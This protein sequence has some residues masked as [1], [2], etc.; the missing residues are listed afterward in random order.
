MNRLILFVACV[1]SLVSIWPI[2]A[3]CLELRDLPPAIQRHVEQAQS[4]CSEPFSVGRGFAV[5]KDIN[6][7]ARDDYVL[8]YGEAR[9]GAATSGYC[10]SGGCLTQVFVSKADGTFSVALDMNVR[11]LNFIRHGG[12]P[13]M[14]LD[15]HGSFCGGVGADPC[16]KILYFDG[17]RADVTPAQTS[18]PAE[19]ER[20][21]AIAAGLW[22]M[23]NG[24]ARV[25]I[26]FSGVKP[27]KQ[28]AE[29]EAIRYCRRNGGGGS[30][31]IIDG[32]SRN[33][34]CLFVGY[35]R[36]N[37]SVAWFS[38][39]STSDVSDRCMS[40]QF[41]CAKPIGGCIQ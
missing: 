20:W 40:K 36:A 23:R 11:G 4:G 1:S 10:G 41:E 38:G 29:T 5:R 34:G 35:G 37:R 27:T 14:L 25:S 31:K 16:T 30:C 18:A 12:A 15:L 26:G 7:D 21:I 39:S 28:V 9:C 6:D 19:A 32:G 3:S 22:R 33:N 2:Q 17:R 8:D 13:A 24:A